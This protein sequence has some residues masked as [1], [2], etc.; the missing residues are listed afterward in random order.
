MTYSAEEIKSFVKKRKKE[1]L[2]RLLISLLILSTAVTTM[3]V[4]PDV[5]IVFFAVAVIIFSTVYIIKTIIK[6]EPRVLFS[7]EIVGENIK[8]HEFVVTDRRLAFGA[9]IKA[10]APRRKISTFTGGRVRTKPPTS[11]IVYLKVEG[12]DV[13]YLDGLTNA[14]TDIYEIGD[15][16]Y[17]YA[18]TRYPI[19]VGKE[20]SAQPCPI[21]GTANK[22]IE[23]RCITCGLDITDR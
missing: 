15:T 11:A 6:Y 13:I 18:G 8:E 23:T 21:C 17:K 10:V 12:G 3:L 4:F 7:R 14:Q 1:L 16:L 22:L 2:L 5:T 20:V 19:I 9:R